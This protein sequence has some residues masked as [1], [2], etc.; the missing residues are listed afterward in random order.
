[1]S[2]RRTQGRGNLSAEE[3]VGSELNC[4]KGP[5]LDDLSE[6][7]ATEKSF[8]DKRARSNRK[9]L[10][11]I[12]YNPLFVEPVRQYFFGLTKP[13]AGQRVLELGCGKGQ[14]T[15][16]LA[17]QGLI[18]EA[19]DISEEMLAAT[20]NSAL[21]NNC[22]NRISCRK[23]S[24]ERLDYPDA[25]FAA[26]VGS[27]VLHHL[28]LRLA[29]PEMHRVLV[30]GGSGIFIEPLG[31]NPLINFYRKLTPGQRT[32]SEQPMRFSSFQ[33]LEES[34]AEFRHR[35]FNLLTFLP[36]LHHVFRRNERHFRNALEVWSRLDGWIWRNLPPI[37]RFYWITV[38]NFVK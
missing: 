32:V 24:A 11:S 7:Y 6:R 2:L 26:I 8:H 12:V 10:S 23:M 18:V 25:S 13:L 28:D 21:T 35:E 37:R 4:S 9:R 14:M 38:I 30:P 3:V 16:P 20:R 5:D 19:T 29:V 33:T 27:G 36:L 34:F 15:I 1:M 22:A 17:M 31:H